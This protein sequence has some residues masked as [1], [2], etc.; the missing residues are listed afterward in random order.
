MEIPIQTLTLDTTNLLT[1]E[2][3][4]EVTFDY[5]P[6]NPCAFQVVARQIFQPG[7]VATNA[8]PMEAVA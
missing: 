2:Q 1:L 3:L 4:N 6:I 8:Q 5:A 7:S